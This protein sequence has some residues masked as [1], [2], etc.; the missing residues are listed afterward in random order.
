MNSRPTPYQYNS[1]KQSDVFFNGF[2]NRVVPYALHPAIML[3][4]GP[5]GSGLWSTR[6]VAT[7][8]EDNDIFMITEG[9]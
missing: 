2:N 8:G 3:T 7:T 5:P 9:S 6:Y 4:K 1:T